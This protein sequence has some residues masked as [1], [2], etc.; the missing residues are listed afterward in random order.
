MG[1][2]EDVGIDKI[3]TDKLSYTATFTYSAETDNS[4]NFINTYNP[5]RKIT[6]SKN[7]SGNMVDD[8]EKN[9]SFNFSIEIEKDGNAI[10]AAEI[11][12]N[13]LNKTATGQYT[14]CS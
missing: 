7:V 11:I 5:I 4:V 2:K 12:S 9:K 13:K 1:T 14:F 3:N 10:D 8:V 6:I